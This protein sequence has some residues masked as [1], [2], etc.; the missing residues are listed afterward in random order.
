M[1]A[2][3]KTSVKI[4][5]TNHFTGGFKCKVYF[6]IT[7]PSIPRFLW[8][9]MC[10]FL[11]FPEVPSKT[12]KRLEFERVCQASKRIIP[13]SICRF[14][15]TS[16]KYLFLIKKLPIK[17]GFSLDYRFH[18][19]LERQRPGELICLPSPDVWFENLTNLSKVCGEVGRLF[20]SKKLVL[21]EFHPLK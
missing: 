21:G 6:Q 2:L 15:W 9:K 13:G 4:N 10:F 3:I 7:R 17:S 14:S 20:P 19:S 12:G 16:S 5:S 1:L 18:R 8:G 11:I